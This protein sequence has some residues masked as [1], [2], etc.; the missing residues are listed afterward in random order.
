MLI[1][2]VKEFEHNPKQGLQMLKKITKLAC[3]GCMALSAAVMADNGTNMNMGSK[4][5]GP[6][7][8]DGGFTLGTSFNVSRGYTTPFLTLGYIGE[9]FLIDVGGNFTNWSVS[10]EDG[11]NFGDLMGHLGFRAQTYQNLY[12]TFGAT[13]SV[14]LGSDDDHGRPW[15]VGAF[16]GLDLQITKH[17]L[18]STKINAYNFDRPATDVHFNEV[19]SSGSINLAYVF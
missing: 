13:G 19:F 14:V 10:S 1:G 12:F 16:V 5:M 4:D 15:S 2:R 18:L 8:Y 17:F 11:H 9:W 6:E 7:I 3:L